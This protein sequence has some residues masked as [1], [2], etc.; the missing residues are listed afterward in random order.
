[1]KHSEKITSWT[2]KYNYSA[3]KKNNFSLI[4]WK[5]ILELFKIDKIDLSFLSLEDIFD[6]IAT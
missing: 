1:M 5:E 4:K 6:N 3:E 2:E